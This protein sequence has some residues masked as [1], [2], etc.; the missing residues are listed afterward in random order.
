MNDDDP[1]LED[2][3]ETESEQLEAEILR[4]N[5]PFAGDR[6]G[7]TAEEEVAGEGLDRALAE[8]VPDEPASAEAASDVALEIVDDDL[9]D[10][11]KELVD[12]AAIERDPFAAPEETAVTVRDDAP[13]VTDHGEE[14]VDDDVDGVEEYL[15][16][17]DGE[18]PTEGRRSS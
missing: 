2:D 7:T 14:L 18:G 11:E 6:W 1:R 17:Q 4:A 3:D 13:G 12:D 10:E 9:T 8:E 5:R 15:D 16:E